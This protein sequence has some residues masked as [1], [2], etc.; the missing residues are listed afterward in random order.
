[1]DAYPPYLVGH[2]VPLVALSGLG[3]PDPNAFD[4][5]ERQYASLQD[6]GQ[7]IAA[8]LPDVTGARAEDL[9]DCFQEFD[10]R[11]AAWNSRPGRGK[12][13]SMGFT[14]RILGRVSIAHT[15]P[16][17]ELLLMSDQE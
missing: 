9:L 5:V 13:G 7:R 17:A 6:G 11:D 16:I 15:G 10:A 8:E 12:M 3:T 4:E 14:Y 2:N 1:M